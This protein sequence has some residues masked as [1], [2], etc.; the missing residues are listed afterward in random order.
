MIHRGVFVSQT[1]GENCKGWLVPCGH[2]VGMGEVSENYVVLTYTIV[3]IVNTN[4]NIIF[5]S[6]FGNEKK[7]LKN[8]DIL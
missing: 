7:T 3:C 6:L 2:W 1:A 8:P 5:S 4:L